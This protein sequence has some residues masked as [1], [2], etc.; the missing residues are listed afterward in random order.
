MAN[1]I[2]TKEDMPPKQSI[3]V[4]KDCKKNTVAVEK[5]PKQSRPEIIEVKLEP[6]K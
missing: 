5:K 6:A 4:C 2:L 1:V 3:F